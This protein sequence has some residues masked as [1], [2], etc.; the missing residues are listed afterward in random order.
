[1]CELAPWQPQCCCTRTANI[2]GIESYSMQQTA[3]H[4]SSY[5]SLQLMLAVLVSVSTRP[6]RPTQG[7]CSSTCLDHSG[8]VVILPGVD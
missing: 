4:L 1:M 5:C 3:T 8:Q 2:A 7:S 6:T